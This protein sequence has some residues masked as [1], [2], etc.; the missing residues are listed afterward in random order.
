MSENDKTPDQSGAP[1]DSTASAVNDSPGSP[2]AVANELQ[3]DRNKMSGSWFRLSPRD[4]SA[5]LVLV[6]SI[7]GLAMIQY[8]N[9][10]RLPLLLMIVFLGS[11]F[12]SGRRWRCH[13]CLPCLG[14]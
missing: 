8:E 14:G 5:V 13:F 7:L 3:I 1:D 9:V 10:S 11:W 2:S 12:G 4:T 6:A